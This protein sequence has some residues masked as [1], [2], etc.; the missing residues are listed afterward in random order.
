MASVAARADQACFLERLVRYPALRERYRQDPVGTARAEGLPALARELADADAGLEALEG[1]E[2]KSSFAGVFASL[3]VEGA[4]LFDSLHEHLGAEVASAAVPRH[5]GQGASPVVFEDLELDG[6]EEDNDPGEDIDEDGE[7]SPDDDEDIDEDGEDSPD[8]D[9]DSDDESDSSDDDEDSDDDEEDGSEEEG[10]DE[11]P[12]ADDDGEE[13]N[14]GGSDSDDPTDAFERFGGVGGAPVEYPGD[15]APREQIAAWMARAAKERGLPP[16]LPVMASLVESGLQNLSYGH[17]D[18]VGFF[19]MRT[20]IWD[21]GEYAGYARRPELQLEWF[22]DHAEAMGEQRVS[23]GLPVDDPKQFGEWI[24]DVERPAA[25]YRGR[26][27]LQLDEARDVLAAFEAPEAIPAA[28]KRATAALGFAKSMMGTP[29]KWGGESPTEGFDCS[30]LVQWAYGKAGISLP[31]VTDQQFV[32]PGGVP[33][34][35]GDLLPGDLVFFRDS[36]GYVHHVGMSL[37]GDRFVG[38]P[39]TGAKVRIDSLKDAYW[40]KE[41]AGGRRFDQVLGRGRGEARVLPAV[42][43]S[44]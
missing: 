34:K 42:A 28:G 5:R 2:S 8:D 3:A 22:L 31:R 6:D 14:V 41:F 38:A 24:A 29:Y 43:R 1:R 35:R 25:Q 10:D 36:T 11:A 37:G 40:A 18:S 44:R 13:P 7:D 27:Q 32:A 16:E 26:Y 15:G 19:Q 20:S 30:G 33:V 21:Q 17:A 12:D 39:H 9:D 23:R 4:S